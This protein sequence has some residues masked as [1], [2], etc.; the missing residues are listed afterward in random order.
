ME[1]STQEAEV[2]VGASAPMCLVQ[3]DWGGNH[4]PGVTGMGVG[5]VESGAW[6]CTWYSRVC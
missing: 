2:G 4:M 1:E 6:L 3:R 5:E